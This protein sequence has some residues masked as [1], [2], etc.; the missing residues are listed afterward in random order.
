METRKLKVLLDYKAP[1]S[2][3][4]DSPIRGTALTADY[5]NHAVSSA[6]PQG[7]EGQQRRIYSRIQRKLDQAIDD[8][9]EDIELEQAESDLL[10]K[11]FEACKVPAAIAKYFVVLEDAIEEAT[12][13]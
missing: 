2:Q 9:S 13:R 3:N 5:I 7:L 11:A 12:K 8:G 6:H 1:E 10:R 4:G